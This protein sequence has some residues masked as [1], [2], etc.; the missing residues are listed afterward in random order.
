MIFGSLISAAD[1]ASV[2]AL[3]KN[4]GVSKRLSILTPSNPGA[5]LA[6]A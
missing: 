6:T 5:R 2:L 4:L 1:P 3:F